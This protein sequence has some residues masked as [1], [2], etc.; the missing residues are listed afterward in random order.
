MRTAAYISF[1][2]GYGLAIV[3]LVSSVSEAWRRRDRHRLDVVVLVTLL[4]L[5][6]LVKGATD[7]VLG[8]VRLAF[9]ALL[10]WALLRLVRHFRHVPSPIIQG[11][12]AIAVVMPIVMASLHPSSARALRSGAYFYFALPMW[13]VA[14]V[15]VRETRRSS[16]VKARRLLV[17]ATGTVLFA[18]SFTLSSFIVWFPPIALF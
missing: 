13:F 15:L 7:G 18:T 3:A 10:P 5:P 14:V 17:A 9:L 4:L 2:V 12:F 8:S 11:S 1:Y 16:G 6:E